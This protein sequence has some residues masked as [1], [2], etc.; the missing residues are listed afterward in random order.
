MIHINNLSFSYGFQPVLKDI[1]FSIKET[2]FLAIIGPNGGGK[3]TLLKL[4]LGLLKPSNGNV[5]FDGNI[6]SL[7]DI[8]YAPQVSLSDR[9]FPINVMDT[10][11][12]GILG[13]RSYIKPIINVERDSAIRAL[14][15]VSMLGYKEQQI[16]QLSEGQ[17]QRVFIA[18]ALISNPKILLLDEPAASVD[19]KIQQNLYS[20][21]D[22]LK[23]IVGIVMITHDIGVISRHVDEVACLNCKLHYHGTPE[24][25]KDIIEK[26]YCCDVDLI[27]HGYPHRVLESH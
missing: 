15:Q 23:Q 7:S 18:R 20:L 26:T 2:G 1:S 5:A 24:L 6:K 12:L 9:T 3:T 17:R 10:V 22:R 14:E 11:L 27:A 16:G 21:L 25:S 8:G 13:N 19:P 4:I